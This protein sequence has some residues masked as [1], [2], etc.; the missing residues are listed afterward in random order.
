[1][2]RVSD[3]ADGAVSASLAKR[4]RL[5][6]ALGV[7]AINLLALGLGAVSLW[8]SR[9][10]EINTV[11][12]RSRN[13]AAAASGNIG[14]AFDKVDVALRVVVDELEHSLR[15]GGIRPEQ[16]NAFIRRQKQYVPEIDAIRATNAAG[17]VVLGQGTGAG[18]TASYADRDFFTR[19]KADPGVGLIVTKPLLGRVSHKW[20]ISLNRRINAPDGSFAGVASATISLDQLRQ[21]LS[22]FDIGPNGVLTIRDLDLG[23]VVRGAG[24]QSRRDP[25]VGSRQVSTDLA[26]ALASGARTATYMAVTPTDGIE[27]IVSFQRLANLPYVVIVGLASADHLDQWRHERDAAIGLLAGFVLIISFGGWMIWVLYRRQMV[28]SEELAESN[29]R[30][31]KSL[32]EVQASEKRFTTM[33]SAHPGAMV[34]TSLAEGRIIDANP[35]YCGAAGYSR[36]ELVGRLT[37]DVDLWV[38]PE[39]RQRVLENLQRDGRVRNLEIEYRA[40]RET[41]SWASLSIERVEIDGTDYMLSVIE[42]VAERKRA[43]AALRESE[44]RFRGVFDSVG[45]AI[46][47]HDAATGAIQ[48][49]NRRMA[50][51]YG[52][53]PE[54]AKGYGPGALSSGVPPYTEA[55]ALD[56]FRKVASD[57]PQVFEWQARRPGDGSLF[58]VEVNLREARLGDRDCVIAVVRDIG[59]EKEARQ[60]KADLQQHL[61]QQVAERTR[62]L[63][64]A[65]E[66]AEAANVAKSAFL[67]NMS[68]EIRTPINAITGMAHLIRRSGVSARQAERLEKIDV[69]GRHLLEIVSAILDLSKI[70]AGRFALAE[71]EFAPDRLLADVAA[72]VRGAA[73]QK[74]LALIVD[75][76]PLPFRLLGDPTRLRQALLNF[77]NNAVKFTAR[78][79]VSLR[80]RLEQDGGDAVRLRFEVQDTGIGIAEDVI[81]RLFS[82]FEQADNSI[83]R[84]YGGTGLGIAISRKF[85][86]LMGG[87][88]GVVS[89]P[90]TGST[91]WLTAVL[92]KGAAAA[93]TAPTGSAGSAEARLS[94]LH[95]GR[96]ILLADDEPVNRE[97]MLGLLEDV[98]F[99][100]DVAEDGVEALE[101]ATGNDYDLILMDMQMPRMD[102]L[103]ATRRIRQL[104]DGASVPILAMT[105]NAFVEDKKRCLDAGMNDFI[106]KPFD[107]EVLF[108]VLLTWLSDAPVAAGIEA[109]EPA[110]EAEDPSAATPDAARATV[111]VVDDAPENL[112]VLN[113]LL[114]P[115]YRMLAATSGEVALRVA[116]GQPRPDLILLDVMMPGMDGYAVLARLRE[117]PATRDIP[118]MF[119]T[120]LSGSEDEESGMK[121]GAA[122]YIT[123]PIKPAVVLARVATQLA[124]KKARDWLADQ[125]AVLEA[126][127][128]RR[129]VEN[130]L[131]Q[132]VSIRALA[133]LAETR[134]PETGNH[135]LRTQGYVQRLA[136]GLR[137][138]SRFAA[139]LNDRYIDLLSRS[140]PLHDVGKVGIPDHILLKPGPLTA[141]E[142]AV[143]RTHARLGSEAIEQA[144]R[145]IEMSLEFLTL[146]K[147][148][149][150]WHHE[151]WDGKGYPDGLAG[152]QIPMSARLMA[153]A[154]VF[155][156]L[157]TPRVYKAALPYVEARDIIVAE[158]GKH[159]DPD[160]TD[161]FVAGFDDFVAIAE[162][163]RD[164]LAP[165]AAEPGAAQAPG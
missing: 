28:A 32:L 44:Q 73:E 34:L 42:D 14:F 62:E 24:Q 140:A 92:K 70:E 101:R 100:V 165:R 153:L 103:E 102:G 10:Q 130:D 59:L 90:G 13:I 21:Y 137:R 18:S 148:I 43:E 9:Q 29:R 159:F 26:T 79:S 156:A 85:A 135:I 22:R 49:V 146:A 54:E 81:P 83:T 113:E 57:G 160:V 86:Q 47:I 158:R 55:A 3:N 151:K 132:R 12:I 2:G 38:H 122:D 114:S 69:A 143:M 120:A 1:M 6:L 84:R 106:T 93:D 40:G 127:V 8:N 66:S 56:W 107:P 108:E 112:I 74:K 145:D 33:F 50:K 111:L 117:N 147:E 7:L 23:F 149:A 161:A 48:M 157:V 116:A 4:F 63:A 76:E 162:R 87:D 89:T 104:H 75:A 138:H 36:E 61:E 77:A 97:V 109:A 88:A 121:L 11:E 25:E 68:H 125:N 136:D 164:V 131:T 144:E 5:R 27:R 152:E 72:M 163:H 139:T 95:A 142:W 16:V 80:F 129:M 41:N 58:W 39:D 82:A 51:M 105:A 91:F 126:E 141:D 64:L 133:H 134:D 17:E 53:A 67:A 150:R 78:G 155:D 118:V 52:I 37:T 30:L 154:D 96:R 124:A 31:S 99:D 128:A 94:M 115:S 19:H 15:E 20:V 119:L 71:S 46:F 98:G 123:K 110:P 35:A 45:E 65:K 60:V